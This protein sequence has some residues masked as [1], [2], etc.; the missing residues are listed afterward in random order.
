MSFGAS[1]VKRVAAY[2][3][4]SLALVAAITFVAALWV[5]NNHTRDVEGPVLA[6]L[7]G[8]HGIHEIDLIALAIEAALVLTLTVILIL[9]F[10][11]R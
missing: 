6:V 9:G 5:H 1:S 10:R 3:T 2:L 4:L 8:T 11:R 7:W